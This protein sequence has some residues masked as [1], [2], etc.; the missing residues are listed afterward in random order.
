MRVSMLI[1]IGHEEA[2]Y[3]FCGELYR[4]TGVKIN[5]QM[6][7]LE[8][9]GDGQPETAEERAPRT[10]RAA[11]PA[12]QAQGNGGGTHKEYRVIRGKERE[13]VGQGNNNV[14]FTYLLTRGPKR[15]RQLWEETGL[16]PKSV[17]SSLH[18]L[19]TAGVVESFEVQG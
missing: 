1:P 5:L 2:I 7:D 17:E 3:N 11:V 4:A 16:K 6:E 14:V 8:A 13:D 18:A 19:R 12:G 9:V 15:A 10:R